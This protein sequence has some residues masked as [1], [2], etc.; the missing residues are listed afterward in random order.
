MGFHMKTTID[1]NDALLLKAKQLA[2]A[3]QQ[4][5]KSILET[6]LRQFLEHDEQSQASFKLRKHSFLGDGLQS[7]ITPGDW[8]SIRERAYEGRGG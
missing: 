1:I 8:A 7:D 6:A 4:S 3:R 2:A 5:L